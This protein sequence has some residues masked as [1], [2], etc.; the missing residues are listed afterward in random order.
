MPSAAHEE[1]VMCTFGVG[2]GLIAVG[3]EHRDCRPPLKA[4]ECGSDLAL[5]HKGEGKKMV[6]VQKIY[7]IC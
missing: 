5:C 7:K 1:S 2:E 3:E 4:L 6:V